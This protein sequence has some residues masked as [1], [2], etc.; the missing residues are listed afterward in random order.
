MKMT[1]SLFDNIIDT[2]QDCIFWK[3]KER[4]FVGVNQAF[5]DFYGFDS[6]DVLI[7]KTDEDMGWHNDP[8]PF[9]QD[10]MRVLEGESTYKVPGKCMVRGEERD[11]IATKRPIYGGNEIVGL[12]G[13]FSDVTDVMRRKNEM[14]QAQIM[15][16]K[17]Q[18]RQYPYFDKLMDEVRMDEILDSLTGIIARAYILDFAKA[19]IAQKTP[20]TFAIIDLDNFKFINDTYGHY[21][22]DHVLMDVSRHLALYTQGYGVAGRFGGDELL[23]INLKDIEYPDKAQF[24]DQM[25]GNHNILRKNIP[26]DDHNLFVT[27]TSGCA[28]YPNDAQSYDELFGL[29]D[30]TLYHGK[31]KGRNCYTIYEEQKHRDLEIK[32]IAK[33]GVYTCMSALTRQCEMVQGFENKLQ[34]VVPL[35]MD[36]LQISDLYYVG[37]NGQIHSVLG[38]KKVEDVSDIRQLM[39]E[40]LYADSTLE[41]IQHKSPVLYEVLNRW[42]IEAVMIVRMGIEKETFGYLVCA[43]PKNQRIWQENECGILYFLAKLLAANIYIELEARPE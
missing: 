20:F 5:L 22:G 24:F 42:G 17:E 4:R 13:S 1:A 8:A 29:I 40:E 39:S 32:K 26:L 16:T 21:A 10:E 37:R 9:M 31:S 12:V 33:Q 18:L 38:K 3:D 15:Y 27:G 41:K 35:L 7:G 11:I 14:D 28:T 43:E 36:E 19:L 2:A 34:A 30:K 25:Y 6:P 23:I